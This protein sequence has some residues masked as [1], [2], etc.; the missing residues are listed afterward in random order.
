MSSASASSR[1][2]PANSI[3][4]GKSGQKK[5][6]SSSSL[7]N[8]HTVTNSGKTQQ[9]NSTKSD[10]SSDKSDEQ[11]SSNNKGDKGGGGIFRPL[12]V[13]AL[14]GVNLFRRFS[15]YRRLPQDPPKDKLEVELDRLNNKID[16]LLD[17]LDEVE[18][19][20]ASSRDDECILCGQNK[21]TMQTFPCAHQ[22][23]CRTCFV[24]TIQTTV[25]QKK[26]PLRCVFCRAKILRLKQHH[27]GRGGQQP[28]QP[29]QDGVPQS[30]SNYSLTRLSSSSSNHSFAS[31]V[32]S[33]S[34]ASTA[35]ARSVRSFNF[36]TF[37]NFQN[38]NLMH[39]PTLTRTTSGTSFSGRRRSRSPSPVGI[40]VRSRSMDGR[41]PKITV[42]R[43]P[44]D[45][46]LTSSCTQMSMTS[47][48][49]SSSPRSPISPP[50]ST[51]S[52]S[53]GQ[54][55]GITG[56]SFFPGNNGNNGA[57][58]NASPNSPPGSSNGSSPNNT[59]QSSFNS[60]NANHHQ[61]LIDNSQSSLM[62]QAQQQTIT[63]QVAERRTSRL[64]TPLS[65][66][67]ESRRENGSSLELRC[68][69]DRSATSSPIT[70]VDNN[71]ALIT[72]EDEDPGCNTKQPIQNKDVTK[73][74]TH[75][76]SRIRCADKI[77]TQLELHANAALANR[78]NEIAP[79]TKSS[80]K[81]WPDPVKR[82]AVVF[83][84]MADRANA[85]N[86]VN[87]RQQ[88]LDENLDNMRLRPRKSVTFKD[89]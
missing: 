89:C 37:S 59:S 70:P 72:W 35:S 40:S 60:N 8:G 44:S 50:W 9:Q 31:G 69:P 80:L 30:A 39:K 87:I 55:N 77:L 88:S 64:C 2:S 4:G 47:P 73:L 16:N 29:Q 13:L 32:S 15:Q 56:G 85:N 62:Q 12:V 79:P 82:N 71:I 74:K 22:V 63:Y 19:E 5:S 46:S 61:N 67:K 17:K 26:L 18:A 11:Q 3:I 49:S 86:A 53:P 20:K 68:S 1:S 28:Q 65:P 10:S 27:K 7:H 6:S 34:S 36:D 48:G 75:P 38:V 81:S 33:V 45:E 24:R 54:H 21:A 25:A 84:D 51:G 66:I 57:S 23:V 78:N 14:P 52:R 76:S 41:M 83:G 58:G 43:T 42:D